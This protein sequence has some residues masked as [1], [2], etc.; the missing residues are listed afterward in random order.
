M[1]DPFYAGIVFEIERRILEGDQGAR[2]RGIALTDSQVISVLTKGLGAA[3]GK[4]AKMPA[5]SNPRDEFLAEL[6]GKL[7]EARGAILEAEGDP[8]PDTAKPIATAD[9]VIALRCVIESART[10]KGSAPGSRFYLDFLGPFIA[11]A[12]RL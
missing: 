9:W 4:P 12:S 6:C 5:T 8:D 10:R 2:S 3:E 11:E 1:K 7:K